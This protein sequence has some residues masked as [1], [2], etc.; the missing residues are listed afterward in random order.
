MHDNTAFLRQYGV[1][2]MQRRGI[3]ALPHSIIV[4]LRW[5]A[6]H[7]YDGVGDAAPSTW[8]SL[9]EKDSIVDLLDIG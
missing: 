6:G 9:T 4:E 2:E 5:C 1:S 3:A 8:A 7:E